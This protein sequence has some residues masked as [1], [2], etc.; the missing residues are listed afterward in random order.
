MDQK[1]LI[2][3]YAKRMAALTGRPQYEAED[4]HSAADAL[5]CELL[6]ALG[7]GDVVRE[8]NKIEKLYS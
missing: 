4:D 5:L 6:E 7:A 3:Q 1:A 2:E 8:Y